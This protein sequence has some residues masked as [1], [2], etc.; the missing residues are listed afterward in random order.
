MGTVQDYSVYLQ[1]HKRN[2]QH[3]EWVGNRQAKAGNTFSN[4]YDL[5]DGRTDGP[6]TDKNLD[7]ISAALLRWYK[8]VNACLIGAASHGD[9][10]YLMSSSFYEYFVG[11]PHPCDVCDLIFCFPLI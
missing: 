9:H 4:V 7:D 11:T 2:L 10:I 6:T 3:R 5:T 1:T 8:Y